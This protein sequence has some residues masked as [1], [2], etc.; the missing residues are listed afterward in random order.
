MTS[1]KPWHLPS[2]GSIPDSWR[3]ARSIAWRSLTAWN[4]HQSHP[5]L[6]HDHAGRPSKILKLY[7]FRYALSL[8]SKYLFQPECH[9]II[10]QGTGSETVHGN[11][12]SSSE[13]GLG[14]PGVS[15]RLSLTPPGACAPPDLLCLELPGLA[16]PINT[17]SSIFQCPNAPSFIHVFLSQFQGSADHDVSAFSSRQARQ[18][19]SACQSSPKHSNS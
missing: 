19:H 18:L 14:C 5:I 16:M 1:W 4:T 15:T 7:Y 12:C 17:P 9:L 10:T 11:S 2:S 3:R 8:F 6:Y 13:G